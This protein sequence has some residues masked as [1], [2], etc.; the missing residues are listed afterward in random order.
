MAQRLATEYVKT[1]LIV[2]EAQWYQL[3]QLFQVHNL[4]FK[5]KVLENGDHEVVFEQ[6]SG[7]ESLTLTFQRKLGK[8]VLEGSCRFTDLQLANAMRKAVSQFKGDAVVNRIYE[9]YTLEY[10]YRNGAVV[11]ITERSARGER[12]VYEHKDTLG[13]LSRTFMNGSVEAQIQV[14]RLEINDWLDRRNAC[15]DAAELRGIDAELNRLSHRLFVLE[16]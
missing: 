4:T 3:I 14:V 8:F 2:N 13:E 16:A 5:V 12:L 10:Q 15:K 6:A 7:T 11:R 1:C 9:A